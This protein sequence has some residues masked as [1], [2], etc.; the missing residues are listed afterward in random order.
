MAQGIL[1]WGSLIALLGLVL[2]LVLDILLDLVDDDGHTR[3]KRRGYTSS[4]QRDGLE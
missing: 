2:V 4:N 1:V 3:G